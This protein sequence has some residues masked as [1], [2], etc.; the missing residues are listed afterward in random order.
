[1]KFQFD[2]RSLLIPDSKVFLVIILLGLTLGIQLSKIE[3]PF[4]GHFATY[5]TAMASMSRNMMDEDFKELLYPKTDHLMGQKKSLHLNQ[6]P[7][8]SLIAAV[9]AKVSGGSLEFW[10]RFQAIFFH[11]ISIFLIGVLGAKF[12]DEKTAWVAP[13][14]FAL[15]PYALIYGQ[16]FMLESFSLCFLLLALSLLFVYPEKPFYSQL[17][18]MISALCFS[19]AVTG[20]LHFIF[21]YPAFLVALVYREEKIWILQWL[22]FS[23]IAFFLPCLW[24]LHTYYAG[25]ASDHLHTNLFVQLASSSSSSVLWSRPEFYK[26]LLD[27][28]SLNMMT[29]LVFPFLFL[30]TFLMLKRGKGVKNIVLVALL[31]GLGVILMAPQKVMDHDFYLYGV[32]PFLILITAYGLASLLESFAILR[33]FRLMLVL[34]VLYL[35]VSGRYFLHPIFK[36]PAEDKNILIAAKAV[37]NVSQPYETVIAIG[38]S[39]GIFEYYMNRPARSL[40]LSLI[41]RELAPYQKN[42]QFSG[43]NPESHVALENAMKDPVAWL[44]HLRGLGAEYVVVPKKED[45]DQYPQLSRYLEG[46]YR[47]LSIPTDSYELY[48]L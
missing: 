20:R 35:G 3:R 43:A 2:I 37:Q 1:M 46:Q 5:Q 15:S 36:Y 44:E 4:F 19:I 41:G 48:R 17:M 31:G 25:M 30:G 6:Y 21:F 24:Y 45:L 28:V 29:P 39:T 26:S 9:G 40:Q 34:I 16:S 47:A 32:F 42:T 12:F 22:A 13:T 23:I 14:L 10:G 7:F 11:L 18:V 33:T 8:A 38:E 27:T